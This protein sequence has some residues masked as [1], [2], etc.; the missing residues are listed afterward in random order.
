MHCW[1]G[2]AGWVLGFWEDF[3]LGMVSV[4]VSGSGGGGGTSSIWLGFGLKL[5]S[6]AVRSG[7]GVAGP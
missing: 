5:G 4:V 3:F 6:G 1:D 2:W 7:G